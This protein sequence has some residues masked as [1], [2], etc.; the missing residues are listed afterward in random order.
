MDR[1]SWIYGCNRNAKKI[2]N[3]ITQ[4]PYKNYK[5]ISKIWIDA[6]K[7]NN[8]KISVTDFFPLVT[9]KFEYPD[10]KDK[11]E[12]L[13]IQCMLERGILSSKSVYVTAAHGERE[14][15]RYKK[16]ALRYLV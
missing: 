12:T 7:R 4:T 9:L 2:K 15:K 13:F 5:N 1:K 11:I 6:A 14:L 3:Q 8:L 16:P 10:E